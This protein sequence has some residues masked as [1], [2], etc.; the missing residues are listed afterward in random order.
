L[1]RVIRRIIRYA[2][3]LFAL[4]LVLSFLSPGISPKKFWIPSFLGLAYPYI[5]LL[6]LAFI[7]FW[8]LMKKREFI[9]SFL[10]ILLGWH[11]LMRYVGLHPASL[12]KLSYYRGLGPQE[13]EKEGQMKIM[14]FNVR[15]FDQY[16]WAKS[17]TT[18]QDIIRMLGNE[19]PDILCLQ[20]FYI[21]EGG[22]FGPEDLFRA[23]ERTP[24]RHLTYT[25]RRGRNRYGIAIFSQYPILRKGEVDINST[26]SICSYADIRVRDD[27]IRVYNMHLQSTRLN[28]QHY[29]FIDS[30]KFRYDNQQMEEIKD[31][32]YRLRDAFITR[33]GQADRIA[34]HIAHC[35]YTVILCGDFN[36]TPVSYTYR[37]ISKGLKDAFVECGF[38]IG[39]TY[40]GKFPS[41]RIDYIMYSDRLEARHYSRKRVR[42]SD[43]FPVE[44]FLQLK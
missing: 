27:T 11:T 1:K 5:L 33:A 39:R 16:G 19:D 17:P 41:F 31:I 37:R 6:N 21:T 25:L 20:E 4:L 32:S 22:A 36:D 43:H 44:A 9:I 34:E 26:M 3:L 23:L 18:R 12:F 30:L 38:G 29:R 15:A 14:S 8:I 13:R 40:I 42:L 2:N 10:A 28:S 35:P 24:N 7:A